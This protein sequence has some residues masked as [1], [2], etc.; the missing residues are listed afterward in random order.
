MSGIILNLNS[1]EFET[2]VIKV[3]QRQLLRTVGLQ[4]IENPKD[5][6]PCSLVATANKCPTKLVRSS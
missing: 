2:Q 5:I 1:H 4:E 3:K 6:K